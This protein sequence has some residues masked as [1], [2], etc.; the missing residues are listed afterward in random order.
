MHDRPLCPASIAAPELSRSIAVTEDLGARL[1]G[2]GAASQVS[3][4][5]EHYARHHSCT[6]WACE[7]TDD[8]HVDRVSHAAERRAI[9]GT[10]WSVMLV[11]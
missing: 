11:Q 10:R 6:G 5:A 1:P 2:D 9:L 7:Q 4:M 3:A 8:D